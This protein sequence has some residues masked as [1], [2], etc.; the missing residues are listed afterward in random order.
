[1]HQIKK[2]V[3]DIECGKVLQAHDEKAG[4]FG[5]DNHAGENRRQ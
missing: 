4:F 3:K 2:K 1:M 5:N